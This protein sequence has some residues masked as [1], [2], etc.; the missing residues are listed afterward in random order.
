MQRVIFGFPG[1]GNGFCVVL[2]VPTAPPPRWR[3]ERLSVSPSPDSTPRGARGRHDRQEP[4]PRQL[5]SQ[6]MATVQRP[7]FCLTWG[8][9]WGLDG[10]LE[11]GREQKERGARWG[12]ETAPGRGGWCVHMQA[13]AADG[14]AA[15]GPPVIRG[16]AG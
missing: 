2:S 12:W 1:S 15:S 13:H 9:M 16:G 8:G 7:G 10:L 5:F 6:V 4:A 3:G 14:S 11:P